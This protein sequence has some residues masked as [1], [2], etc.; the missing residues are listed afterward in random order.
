MAL[1]LRP[2]AEAFLSQEPRPPDLQSSGCGDRK[3]KFWE[4]VIR[5]NSERSPSYFYPLIPGLVISWW[6]ERKLHIL[7]S[8]LKHKPHPIRDNS[9]L[10]SSF[11]AWK[12]GV[13]SLYPLRS[14]ISSGW[15]LTCDF[16][17]NPERMQPFNQLID[18]FSSAQEN[19]LLVFNY[20]FFPICSRL[21]PAGR[22]II[23]PLELLV[24]FI[25][26]S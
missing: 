11:S 5:C 4:Q 25:K 10:S 22:A 12:P 8:D 15:A 6:G 26:P 17:I 24:L 16:L 18:T 7:V 21:S 20:D 2:L 1:G 9:F 3:S 14:C 13:F 19:F 23:C